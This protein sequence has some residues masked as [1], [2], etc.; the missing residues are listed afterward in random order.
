VTELC[1]A[2]HLPQS[3]ASRHLKVLSDDGWV[4]SRADGASRFYRMADDDLEPAARRLWAVVREQVVATPAAGRDAERLR[5]VLAKRRAGADA[6]FESAAGQWDR[7]RTELFGG[8]PELLP[9]AGLLGPDWTVA[10]LGCGT[11]HLALAVAPFVRQVIA[12]DA[13]AAMLR[14]AKTRLGGLANVEVRRGELAELPLEAGSVDL[15]CLVMV[16]PYMDR[17]ETVIREAAR[18][19]KRGGRLLVCDLMPHERAE[20]RQ[21]MGHQRLGVAAEE[22]AAWMDAAGLGSARY[23]PLPLPPDAKGT[24]LFTAVGVKHD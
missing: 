2:L 10:D 24:R 8:R 14:V 13:S 1:A 15:A 5:A 18:V 6:F 11:G 16:L 7:L 4:D 20:Y 9:L 22:L 3:T 19:L 12:V 21:T 17:P 23:V